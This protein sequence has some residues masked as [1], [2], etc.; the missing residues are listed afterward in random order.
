MSNP[1]RG[2]L[3]ITLGKKKYDCKITLDVIVRI[4]T[5]VGRSVVKIMQ[6]LSEGDLTSTEMIKILTPAL[7]SGGLDIKE[8]EVGLVMWD[9]GLSDAIKSI[10]DIASCVLSAGDEGNEQEA[11]VLLV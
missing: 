3:T 8:K 6:S 10:G 4:E 9:A 1:K 11:E 2:E 7:R 5:A